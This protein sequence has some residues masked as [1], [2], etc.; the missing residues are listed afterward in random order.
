MVPYLHPVIPMVGYNMADTRHALHTLHAL[1]RPHAVS[2]NNDRGGIL[3]SFLVGGPSAE[4]AVPEY[5]Y[6]VGCS[7]SRHRIQV[8]YQITLPCRLQQS[9][10]AEERRKGVTDNQETEE[11][12]ERRGERRAERR[13]RVEYSE[14]CLGRQLCIIS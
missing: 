5:S 1:Q 2:C 13:E 11:R 3:E 14:P 4:H 9:G 6:R 10:S 8:S 7:T 12:G